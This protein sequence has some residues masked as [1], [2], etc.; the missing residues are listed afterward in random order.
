[1]RNNWWRPKSVLL[2]VTGSFCHRRREE[3]VTERQRLFCSLMTPSDIIRRKLKREK[4]EQMIEIRI[5]IIFW[6]KKTKSIQ[7]PVCE[8]SG[9]ENSFLFCSSCLKKKSR[10]Y[11]LWTEFENATL[12]DF[13]NFGVWCNLDSTP[14]KLFASRLMFELFWIAMMKAC[15][16]WDG[17][18]KSTRMK[19]FLDYVYASRDR[20]PRN[21]SWSNFF[22]LHLA[23]PCA[24]FIL[25]LL[26][27]LCPE[28]DLAST[29]KI[30]ELM[31][32]RINWSRS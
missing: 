13:P 4:K 12:P 7:K 28:E 2:F 15:G 17:L 18:L 1:M 29:S 30:C 27:T 19:K 22:D 25:F 16:I 24:M 5:Q 26:G 14:H 21:G 9:S 32:F 11:I 10:N 31:L 8:I 20:G 6:V 23:P 3:M